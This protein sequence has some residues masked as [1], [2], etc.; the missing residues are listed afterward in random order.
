MDLNTVRKRASPEGKVGKDAKVLRVSSTHSRGRL[1]KR[2]GISSMGDCLSWGGVPRSLG[3]GFLWLGHRGLFRDFRDIGRRPRNFALFLALFSWLS[4]GA[5][6]TGPGVCC[7]SVGWV[8]F[9]TWPALTTGLELGPRLSLPVEVPTQFAFGR[10]A[11]CAALLPLQAP[12]WL[13]ST[14]HIR[15]S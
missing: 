14:S 10:T 1:S 6:V 5:S 11:G 8:N 7:G 2:S 4:M 15:G 12:R 13:P 9:T 3:I